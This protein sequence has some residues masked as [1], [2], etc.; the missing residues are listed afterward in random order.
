MSTQTCNINGPVANK[1]NVLA[2]ALIILGALSDPMFQSVLP[3]EYAPKILFF[4]GLLLSVIRIFS[5]GQKRVDPT[6]MSGAVK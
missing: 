4:G 3:A 1:T 6:D 2:A 5:T